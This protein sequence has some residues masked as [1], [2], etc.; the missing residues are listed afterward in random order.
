M[1]RIL[2]ESIISYY[3]IKSIQKFVILAEMN[4]NLESIAILGRI[5]ILIIYYIS[6]EQIELNFLQQCESKS[7]SQNYLSI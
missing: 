3:F 6:G 5:T 1:T 4:E 2:S 7:W